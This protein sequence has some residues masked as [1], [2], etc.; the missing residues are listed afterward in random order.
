MLYIL[1]ILPILR[2]LISLASKFVL[3]LRSN[4]FE[5]EIHIS[6]Y[7]I[8]NK[9]ILAITKI[10]VCISNQKCTMNNRIYGNKGRM[11]SGVCMN[12]IKP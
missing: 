8:H 3:K 10:R 12:S 7:D 11:D 6:I 5:L 9:V 4:F 1:I 2:S